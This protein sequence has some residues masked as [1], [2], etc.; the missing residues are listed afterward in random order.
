MCKIRSKLASLCSR[1]IMKFGT[2]FST[3]RKNI[4]EYLSCV[5]EAKSF[6][7]FNENSKTNLT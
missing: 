7:Y 4:P 5:T 2:D 6:E 3:K 1:K